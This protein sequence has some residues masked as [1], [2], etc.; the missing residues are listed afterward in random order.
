MEQQS[1]PQQGYPV[2]PYRVNAFANASMIFGGFAIMSCMIFYITIFFGSLS[3]LF[4][5]LS[6]Q[7]GLR[8][9]TI[10]KVGSIT[11]AVAI[12]ISI[13]LTIYSFI[14][15]IET[16]GAEALFNNPEEVLNQLINMMNQMTQIGG[17]TQ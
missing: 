12:G 3:I 14:F 2:R 13:L 7:D 4:G 11:S 15:L 1:Y 17:V 10:S 5:L 8:M 6:R 16:F 9:P